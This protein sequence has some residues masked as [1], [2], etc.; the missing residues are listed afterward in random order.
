MAWLNDPELRHLVS[1][2]VGGATSLLGKWLFDKWNAPHLEVVLPGKLIK[3]VDGVYW[4]RVCISNNGSSAAIK[5]RILVKFGK[6]ES[7]EEIFDLCWSDL[8][9][10]LE[11][12]IPSKTSRYVDVFY[13]EDKKPQFVAFHNPRELPEKFILTL[14]ATAENATTV[15]KDVLFSKTKDEPWMS[16]GLDPNKSPGEMK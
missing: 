14:F 3:N 13:I 6:P 12:T 1:G 7:Q 9:E 16:I 15:T 5:S 10:A 8:N 4:G 2:I 11:I